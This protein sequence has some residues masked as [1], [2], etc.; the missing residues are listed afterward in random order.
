MSYLPSAAS[1][2]QH[3]MTGGSI[4]E[5]WCRTDDKVVLN[6]GNIESIGNQSIGSFNS[7]SQPTSSLQPLLTANGMNGKPS[8]EIIRGKSGK[9]LISLN[10]TGLPTNTTTFVQFAFEFLQAGTTPRNEFYTIRYTAPGWTLIGLRI[11]EI[12]GQ[13]KLQARVNPNTGENILPA[14][15][16]SL[17]KHIITHYYD[18]ANNIHELRLDGVSQGTNTASINSAP[19]VFD[20]LY[21][22]SGNLPD[23]S[24]SGYF[25]DFIFKTT[26]PPLSVIE[27]NEQFLANEYNISI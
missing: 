7:L 20:I 10:S 18:P 8:M 2:I 22:T 21:G 11:E 3:P 6:L 13:S 1:F 4:P 23:S 19:T 15:P 12:G 14:A 17:G 5:I 25:T 26:V 24:I 9:G 16:L 27:Q